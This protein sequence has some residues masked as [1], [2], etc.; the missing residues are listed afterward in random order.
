MAEEKRGGKRG[1]GRD[2]RRRRR[3]RRRG[4]GCALLLAV[5]AVAGA[6]AAGGWWLA[7]PYKGYA[8]AEKLVDVAP[9]TGAAR[10]LEQLR[11]SG[12]VAS[13]LAA[14]VYLVYVL[15]DP[16]LQ[17]GEYRFAGP[18][19]FTEV[20]RKLIRGDVVSRTVTVVE[21]FTLED[22]AD[23]LARAG[24]G[25]RD[26]FLGLMRSPA[27][28]ADL[29]PAATDLEGYLFPET[30]RFR[31]GTSEAE[32]VATLVKT[33][34]SRFERHVR[35]MISGGAGASGGAGGAG[36]GAAGGAAAAGVEGV[37]GGRPSVREVVTLASIVE[38][39]ARASAERPVI[40]GVY[41]NRLQRR[42]GLDADP[43]VIFALRRLGRWDGTI[44]H[45]DL[46]VDS[47][48]NTY[49]Y[50]GLP[51]GPICSPGLPSLQ[52][53]A[54]P[55]EVPYLYFVSRNDGT[56]VFASTLAEQSHNV[57]IWQRRYWRERRLQDRRE[58]QAAGAGEPVPLLPK[59]PGRSSR[60]HR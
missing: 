25:R 24:A 17:A 9:G 60:P 33:F 36:A 30:Y 53:A 29:D 47:P 39:E 2:S 41:R 42:M 19:T 26:V 27:L 8:G 48:Y 13:S 21:G 11:R 15:K 5:L 34:R 50:A 51:P 3:G 43:T 40:A 20:L 18:I 22:V 12:V 44:H 28:I 52:A 10:I 49:R 23:Q 7:R 1:P 16:P 54:R 59:T 58:G 55:A 32:I 14:R 4:A 57:E 37:D 6:L 56:H 31:I 45:D 35:P 46:R 38:K